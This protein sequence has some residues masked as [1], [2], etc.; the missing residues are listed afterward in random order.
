MTHVLIIEDQ[1]KLR[2]NLQ[3]ILEQEGYLVTAT[4]S[5]D[6]GQALAT[7]QSFDAVILDLNLPG[8]DGLQILADLRAA[9]LATPVLVLTAR[10]SV[11]DRVVGLDT[12][13]DDYVIKP[14][15]HAELLARLAHCFVVAGRRPS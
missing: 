4:G 6:E 8:R 11:D 10:D 2:R 5:G 14:F 1:Y 9:G 7:T 12:G 3:Q 13:A 15:A